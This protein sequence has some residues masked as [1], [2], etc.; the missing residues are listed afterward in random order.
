MR[1]TGFFFLSS[2]PDSNRGMRARAANTA[3]QVL[4]A[5]ARLAAFAQA[6]ALAREAGYAG[7]RR[8]VERARGWIEPDRRDA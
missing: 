2:Q 7:W 8:A 3:A 1:I 4:D 5:A 6:L